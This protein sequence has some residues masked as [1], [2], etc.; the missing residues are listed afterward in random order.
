MRSKARVLAFWIVSAFA[1]RNARAAITL[2][3]HTGKDAGTTTSS[4]LAF[5]ASNTAGNFIAVA[6]RA[7]IVGQSVTVTDTRG[8][9]YRRALQANASLDGVTIAIYYA[10]AIAGGANTVTVTDTL[11][12]GS[13]RFAVFEYAGVAT[14]SSLDGTP[15]MAE[16]TGT[17]MSSGTLTT[18]AGGG[19]VLGV[20]STSDGATYAAGSGATIQERVPTAGTKLAVQDQLQISAGPIAAIG[21]IGASQAWAAAV[22]AFKAGAT[23][24]PVPDLTVAKSH[25]GSF[26][27]GQSGATYTIAAS[28]VG[29][30]PTSGTVTV[31]DALPS[32]LTATSFS[33]TGWSC[34]LAPLSCTRSDALAA[35]ASYPVITLMVNVSASASS[36][37][38]NG[39][40]VSGGGETNTGNDAA[41]DVTTIDPASGGGGPIAL[42]QHASKDA[43]TTSSSTLA[44]SA[45]NTQGNFI[46]VA[47]RAGSAGQS[48]TVTDTRGNTY[49]RA[50]Q[51]SE[52][53][54]NVTVGLYY[55]ENVALGSNTVT[56]SDTVAGGSLRFAILEY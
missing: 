14:A 10:E 2:V 8:N 44:F 27:Q 12:G 37:L 42:V 5:P 26:T 35:G 6:V 53:L 46:L 54:D 38:V 56:V 47:I 13:L 33:G 41:N 7:G 17:A 50:L 4:T 9:T 3:Q 43:G 55:A 36:P 15:V 45:S 32:G 19:L 52:T 49:R 29:T 30:G 11:T 48:F 22:A 39:A 20:F 24:A 40:S 16:G 23:G 18:T 31:G 25:A 1:L 34:T 21:T 28:N 51:Q